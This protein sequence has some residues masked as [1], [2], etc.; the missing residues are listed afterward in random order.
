MFADVYTEPRIGDP[1]RER[2]TTLAL[3]LPNTRHKLELI[4]EGPEAPR[5]REI[6]VY[7]PPVAGPE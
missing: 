1:S 4:A 3:G 5:I 2:A 6:R 7:R